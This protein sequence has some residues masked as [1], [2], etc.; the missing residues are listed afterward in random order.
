MGKKNKKENNTKI[1]DFPFYVFLKYFLFYFLI[2]LVILLIITPI[3]SNAKIF[4][5]RKVILLLLKEKTPYIHSIPFY[6]NI[7]LSLPAFV[8]LF[9]GYRKVEHKNIKP[10]KSEIIVVSLCLILLWILDL[11]G[12][13]LEIVV[14]K[15]S[16]QSFFANYL[17]TILLSIGSIGFPLLLWLFVYRPRFIDTIHNGSNFFNKI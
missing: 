6:R 12:T 14:T 8:A 7:L 3:L 9:L 13:I 4:L 5:V 10:N 16:I 11:L 2:A 17:L 15:L 1:T